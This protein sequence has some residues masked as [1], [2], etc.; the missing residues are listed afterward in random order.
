[1]STLF[2]IGKEAI[3]LVRSNEFEAATP[4]LSR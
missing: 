1:M 3:A 2:N 4:A